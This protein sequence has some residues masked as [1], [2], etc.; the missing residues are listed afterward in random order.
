MSN[1]ELIVIEQLPVIKEQ[2]KLA[3]AEVDKKVEEAMA[4]VCTE[5]NVKIIKEVRA[6]LNKEAKVF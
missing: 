4:L 6:S 2:L 3:S 5:D 1:N